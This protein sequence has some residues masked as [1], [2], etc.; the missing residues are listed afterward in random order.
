MIVQ[1]ATCFKVARNW[2]ACKQ[3]HMKACE[4]M[5]CIPTSCMLRIRSEKASW[6]L[7]E[8]TP[9]RIQDLDPHYNLF[10]YGSPSVFSSVA[11]PDPV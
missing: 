3:A 2:T 5:Y 10:G 7:S 1:A 4:G 11:D 9:N 8:R 6:I